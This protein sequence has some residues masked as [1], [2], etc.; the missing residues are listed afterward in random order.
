MDKY[1]HIFPF[2][3]SYSPSILDKSFEPLNLSSLICEVNLVKMLT[4]RCDLI[5]VG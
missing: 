5:E 1:S 3:F 2:L 4:P